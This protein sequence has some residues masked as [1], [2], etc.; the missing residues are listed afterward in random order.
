MDADTR[1][2]IAHY[3]SSP[4]WGGLEINIMRHL[5]WMRQAGWPALFY[6]HPDTIMF[7]RAA[8]YEVPTRA[9]RTPGRLAAPWKGLTLARLLR[10]DGVRMLCF[11][12]APDFLLSVMAK[13]YSHDLKIVYSQSMHIGGT[14]K[15]F[16]HAWLFR[17]LDAHIVPVQWLVD[18]AREKTVL[19]DDKIH[20]ITRG[21]EVDRFAKRPAQAEARKAL[22]LPGRITLI[23][24]I[25]R[26]D[27]L[28]GQ[29]VAIRALKG[30]RDDGHDVHLL[31]L[32]AE[33]HPG[34]KATL[35]KLVAELALQDY[36]LFRPY[37]DSP[38]IAFAALDIFIM[39][40]RSETYGMVTIEAM[41]CGLPV[42]GTN[43]GGTTSIIDHEQNGLLF[44][45]DDDV[46]L[47]RSLKR[48]LDDPEFAARM[49]RQAQLD[50]T[51]RYSHTNQVSDWEHLLARLVTG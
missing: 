17:Q 48:L 2:P 21:L 15:D 32:G 27:P 38:E 36:V 6:G 20:I 9:I 50:A 12:Q 45:P 1:F 34:Q 18:R 40:T 11:E 26:L 19:P 7:K 47:A 37:V 16:F 43:D 5:H 3:C 51:T 4:G 24:I 33:S 39:G 22:D 35:E 14:K 31:L 10:R 13:K 41:T 44:E 42:V 46:D 8:D 25:G 49:A 23:G 29:D 30:L 28:K